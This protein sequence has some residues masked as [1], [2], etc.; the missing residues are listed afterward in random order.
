MRTLTSTEITATSGATVNGAIYGLFEGMASGMSIG[1]KWGGAGGWGFGAI[2]QLVGLIVPTIMGG[3]YGFV[4]GAMYDEK[5]VS[6][7]AADY[8]SKFG[9]GSTANGGGLL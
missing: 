6:D 5:T 1:G 9:P 8:R 2:S 4:V 7:L 3:A